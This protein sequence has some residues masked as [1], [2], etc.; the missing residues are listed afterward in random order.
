MVSGLRCQR[1]RGKGGDEEK[2]VADAASAAKKGTSG[3]FVG[4]RYTGF[5]DGRRTGKTHDKPQD[6][7]IISV[8]AADGSSSSSCSFSLFSFPVL[9]F[10]TK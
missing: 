8:C 7:E 3:S 9:H 5:R 10:P 1:M 6:H 2:E 4:H